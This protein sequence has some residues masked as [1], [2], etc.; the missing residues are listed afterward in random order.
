LSRFPG[1]FLS[2]FAKTQTRSVSSSTRVAVGITM[3]RRVREPHCATRV[4]PFIA[5][6]DTIDH[7]D[8]GRRDEVP[9]G[10]GRRHDVLAH[11]RCDREQL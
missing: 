9:L 6:D 5:A 2:F 1:C 10:L 7:P 11:R 8:E 4:H 3:R